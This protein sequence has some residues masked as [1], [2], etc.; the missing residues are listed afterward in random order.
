MSGWVFLCWF[1]QSS[2]YRFE[3]GYPI[4]PD[5]IRKF[6]GGHN[7]PERLLCNGNG[8]MFDQKPI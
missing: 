2:I 4:M 3:Y 1:Q 5:R 6:S 7:Q 8:N